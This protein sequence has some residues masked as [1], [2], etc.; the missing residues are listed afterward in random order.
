MLTFKTYLTYIFTFIILLLELLWK[1]NINRKSSVVEV[2]YPIEI[3]MSDCIFCWFLLTMKFAFLLKEA[4]HLYIVECNVVYY[5]IKGY[6]LLYWTFLHIKEHIITVFLFILE[7]LTYFSK[8]C[9]IKLFKF[10][11]SKLKILQTLCIIK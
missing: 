2:C 8:L 5:L 9:C 1:L 11:V 6:I 7:W 10:V 3:Y 4:I